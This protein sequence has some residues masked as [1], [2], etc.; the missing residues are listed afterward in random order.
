MKTLL[1]LVPL[2]L[3]SLAFAGAP[4]EDPAVANL[5]DRFTKADLP[6]KRDLKLGKEWLCTG[7]SAL[8]G[9]FESYDNDKWRLV[10]NGEFVAYERPTPFAVMGAEFQPQVFSF[11]K[12]GLVSTAPTEYDN[13]KTKLVFRISNGDLIGEW[14]LQGATSE[15]NA[16]LVQ[17]G[18]TSK[19]ISYPSAQVSRYLICPKK[20]VRKAYRGGW[21]VP[22]VR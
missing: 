8:A 18:Y 1:V 7:H 22:S 21:Y 10:E 17:A 9:D 4:S 13:I 12:T 5:R 20:L 16:R 2:L 3:S 6:S 15:V 11:T 14:N 19:G